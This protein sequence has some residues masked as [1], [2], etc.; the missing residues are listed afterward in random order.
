LVQ[1]FKN[2]GYQSEILVASVRH[3]IHVIEA[4]KLGAHIVT[5][6]PEILGK[7]LTHPLTNKGLSLFLSDWEKVKKEHKYNI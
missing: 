4:G 2:Y 7:M 5:L 6:P 1:I 3:P